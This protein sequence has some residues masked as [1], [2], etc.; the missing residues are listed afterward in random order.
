MVSALREKTPISL[1]EKLREISFYSRKHHKFTI[2]SIYELIGAPAEEDEAV[3]RLSGIADYEG[4]TRVIAISDYLS[5]CALRPIHNRLMKVL[6]EISNDMTHKHNTIGQYIKKMFES[7]KTGSSID[8]TAATDRLPSR[9]S[10]H[11]L[12]LL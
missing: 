6:R 7:G 2:D 11:I 1:L 10:C 8:L 9:L 3:R 12:A 5:S 4:K